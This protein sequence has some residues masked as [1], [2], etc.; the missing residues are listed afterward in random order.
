L[1]GEIARDGNSKGRLHMTSY[2]PLSDLHTITERKYNEELNF[3]QTEHV[4]K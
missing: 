1:A 2:G 4:C 3:N